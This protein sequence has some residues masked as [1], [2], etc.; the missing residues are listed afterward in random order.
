MYYLH[1]SRLKN[2]SGEKRNRLMYF[3]LEVNYYS[4]ANKNKYR[5]FQLKVSIKNDL[6]IAEDQIIQGLVLSTRTCHNLML[7]LES[8]LLLGLVVT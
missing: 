7:G 3:Q 6:K 5:N 2:Y 4:N 8:A 1:N